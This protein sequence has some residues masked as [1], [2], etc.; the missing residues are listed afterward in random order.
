MDYP[1]TPVLHNRQMAM[2]TIE[3]TWAIEDTYHDNREDK[4]GNKVF[5]PFLFESTNNAA[6]HEYKPE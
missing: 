2:F 1:P 3:Q 5:I 4:G 6:Y